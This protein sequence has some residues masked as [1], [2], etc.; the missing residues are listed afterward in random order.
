MKVSEYLD[1]KKRASQQLVDELAAHT[2]TWPAVLAEYN[3]LDAECIPLAR[4]VLE[5]REARSPQ[6]AAA[7]ATLKLARWKR[8]GTKQRHS[9]RRDELHRQIEA[10]TRDPIQKAVLD[11]IDLVRGLSKFYRFEKI[12]PSHD[13]D[14]KRKRYGVKVSHNADALDAAK[15]RIFAALNEVRDMQHCSLSAV[16]KRIAELNMEFSNLDISTMVVEDVS[17][18]QANDM[19]PQKQDSGD[20]DKATLMPGGKL[21]IHPRV[22]DGKVQDLSDRI[23]KLEKG[24]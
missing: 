17:E 22:T 23:S 7:E 24:A 14:G 13:F 9:L 3:R 11:W 19:K 15:K 2:A 1:S 5:L 10:F 18:D 4:R 12:E 21:H 8:D 6:L 16:E 20:M